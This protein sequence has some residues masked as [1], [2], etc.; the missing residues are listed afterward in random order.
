MTTKPPRKF[1]LNRITYGLATERYYFVPKTEVM[2]NG[3]NRVIGKK[4][5]VTE[6]MK[7]LLNP[8]LR[9]PPTPVDLTGN[10][11]PCPFCGTMSHTCFSAGFI[12]HIACA[13]RRCGA[14]GPDRKT[15]RGAILAWRG[16]AR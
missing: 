8:H 12:N 1:A 4:I 11:G 3:M 7:A 13:A 14:L 2:Q 10:Y 5:D 9:R 16:A 15:L 6:S